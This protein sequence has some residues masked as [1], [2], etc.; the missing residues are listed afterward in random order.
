MNREGASEIE[1]G[2]AECGGR[3]DLVLSAPHSDN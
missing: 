2:E 3:L 1:H